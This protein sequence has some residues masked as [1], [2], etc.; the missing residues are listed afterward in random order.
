VSQ[1]PICGAKESESTEIIGESRLHA[2]EIAIVQSLDE[3]SR[4]LGH[5]ILAELRLGAVVEVSLM[6]Q[7]EVEAKL[8]NR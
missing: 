4:R 6:I 8:L 1:E 2:N 7:A 5:I 3:A